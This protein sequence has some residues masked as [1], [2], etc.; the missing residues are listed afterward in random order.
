MSCSRLL[1]S[2]CVCVLVGSFPSHL[3]PVQQERFTFFPR[4][5]DKLRSLLG[6]RSTQHFCFSGR[7]YGAEKRRVLWF[8]SVLT[9]APTSCALFHS[10]GVFPSFQRPQGKSRLGLACFLHPSPR[11]ARAF[12]ASRLFTEEGVGT[13]QGTSSGELLAFPFLIAFAFGSI[14]SYRG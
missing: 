9:Q 10:L 4:C 2:S 5:Q 1:V 14:F 12:P 11:S 6:S 7:W 13:G 8:G 3:P